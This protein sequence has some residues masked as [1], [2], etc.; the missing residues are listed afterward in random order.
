MYITLPSSVNIVSMSGSS[1]G[2][3]DGKS[4]GAII[5]CGVM[6]GSGVV[7]G[8]GVSVEAM[9]VFEEQAEIITIQ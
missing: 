7:V 1:V 2:T 5:G 3:R 8:L 6:V 4:V 9:G